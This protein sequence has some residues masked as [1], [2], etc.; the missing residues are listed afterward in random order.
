[1]K[2]SARGTST[3]IESEFV[4]FTISWCVKADA[5]ASTAGCVGNKYL[6]EWTLD[7]F[8]AIRFAAIP[9]GITA[10]AVEK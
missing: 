9:G 7:C 3:S 4:D 2:H 5:S 6:I 10:N 8:A 1:M